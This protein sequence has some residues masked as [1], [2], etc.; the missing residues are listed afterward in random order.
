MLLSLAAGTVLDAAPEEAIDAAAAAG[1]DALG[2]RFEERPGDAVLSRLR[3]RIDAAGLRVL[4]VEVVRLT[5]DTSAADVDWLVDTAGALGA[6][7]VLTVSHDDDRDRTRRELER[8]C[9]RAAPL[10]VA[11]GL[12]FMAFTSIG[13]LAEAH[14]VVVAT[15]RPNIGV[16]VDV[17][18]L[19]RSGGTPADLAGPA[20]ARIGYVQLCDGP[21]A[22]TEG[23]GALVDEARHHR[24]MPGEGELPLLDVLAALGDRFED[25]PV[26]VEVQSDV[27]AASLGVSERADLAMRTTRAVL[28]RAG[29][30]GVGPRRR[31]GTA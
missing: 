10:G 21:A 25:I 23:P 3:E 16:L 9:D 5:P 11:I 14:D 20:G 26:S 24:L 17:L 4:D 31:E 15:G 28:D 12:E 30:P 18:H 2:L 19:A 13:R 6:R 27:L 8:L 29:F 7:F 22:A 1:L